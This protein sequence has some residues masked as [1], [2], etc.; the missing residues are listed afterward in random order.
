MVQIIKIEQTNF[1]RCVKSY[2]QKLLITF[3]IAD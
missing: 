3:D 2:N 1:Q